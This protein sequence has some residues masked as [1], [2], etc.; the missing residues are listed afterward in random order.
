MNKVFSYKVSQTQMEDGQNM[1]NYEACKILQKK[2]QP[3]VFMKHLKGRV[4]GRK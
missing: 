1:D 4:F 3:V 2:Y